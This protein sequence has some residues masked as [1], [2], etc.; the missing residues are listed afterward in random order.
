MNKDNHDT[1]GQ[2]VLIGRPPRIGVPPGMS[3]MQK[4]GV[5]PQE[6]SVGQTVSFCGLLRT[7]ADGS[8]WLTQE[9]PHIEMLVD[10]GAYRPFAPGGIYLNV[11]GVLQRRDGDGAQ[12]IIVANDV[13]K[14]M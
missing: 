8:H 11:L 12:R 6:V 10:L 5:S 13:Q 9:S 3:V 1:E 4:P 2:I 7:E 14:F